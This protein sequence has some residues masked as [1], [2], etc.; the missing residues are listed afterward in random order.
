MLLIVLTL[1]QL[2]YWGLLLA[3]RGSGVQV[4]ATGQL[5]LGMLSIVVVAVAMIGGRP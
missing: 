3:L 2:T 1:Q 4:E 5:G